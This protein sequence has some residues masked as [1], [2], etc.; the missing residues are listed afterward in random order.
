MMIGPLHICF[1]LVQGIVNINEFMGDF[2]KWPGGHVE[3]API[4]GQDSGYRR[5]AQGALILSKLEES[6]LVDVTRTARGGYARA[7]ATDADWMALYR[8]G[9]RKTLVDTKAEGTRRKRFVARY[10][11]LVA[12][13]LIALTLEMLLP[14]LRRKRRSS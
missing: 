7:S 4:P 1:R 2:F 8:E 3:G 14:W 10:P 11:W 9:I 12:L 13:A 6:G 5:D